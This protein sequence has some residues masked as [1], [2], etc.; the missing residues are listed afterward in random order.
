MDFDFSLC[1]NKFKKTKGGTHL[2]EKTEII[3]H[4]EVTIEN[5]S[6]EEQ[7]MLY[8]SLLTR[9]LDIYREKKGKEVI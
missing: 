2:S 3:T 1:Y 7:R 6:E 4:G 8:I 5:L 9:V